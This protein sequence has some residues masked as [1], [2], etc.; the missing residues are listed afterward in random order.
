[1]AGS[2]IADLL[3]RYFFRVANGGIT[4]RSTVCG[5]AAATSARAICVERTRAIAR[6]RLNRLLHDQLADLRVAE[7]IGAECNGRQGETPDDQAIPNDF[8]H[9]N[10]QS[11]DPQ[12]PSVA[13]RSK[14]SPRTKY[15]LTS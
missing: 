3:I 12:E 6:I 10:S 14:V 1:M 15:F 8:L 11:A 9:C 5:P 4:A 13:T 2:V 7:S